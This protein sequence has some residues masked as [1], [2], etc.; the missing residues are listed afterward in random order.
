MIALLVSAMSLTTDRPMAWCLAFAIKTSHIVTAK[1]WIAYLC[2][3]LH[4]S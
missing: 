2:M 4:E 1:A 3:G